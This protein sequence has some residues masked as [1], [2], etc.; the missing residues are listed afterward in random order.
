MEIKSVKI[1][2]ECY[3]L[4]NEMYVPKADGNREY[5]LIKIWLKD[6]EPEPEYTKEELDKLEAERKL[7]E[8][9]EAKA[10]ALSTITVEVDGK[11]FDGNESAR[12]NC[13][14]NIQSSRLGWVNRNRVEVS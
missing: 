4:N 11:L 10:R 8:T 7:Q 13:R 1:Q 3:L 9:K 12:L 14:H 5:E 2:G 6:N